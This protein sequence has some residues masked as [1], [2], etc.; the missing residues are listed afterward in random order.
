[1]TKN[2]VV[3]IDNRNKGSITG[4]IKV[5]SSNATSLILDTSVGG[6]TL[7]GSSLK[8]LKFNAEEGFLSF[9]GTTNSV[10]YTA[11]KVPFFKRIFS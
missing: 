2:H 1:M 5:I 9:E 4:V 8:I 10:R 3:N 11:A 7:L 6:L